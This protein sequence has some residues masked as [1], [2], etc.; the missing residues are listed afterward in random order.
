MLE[1]WGHEGFKTHCERVSEFYKARRDVFENA[2]KRHLSGLVE[3]STPE[4]GMFFWYIPF[5]LPE[6]FFFS[7]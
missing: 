3:W 5:V 4:S 2:M 6:E 1:S 7:F